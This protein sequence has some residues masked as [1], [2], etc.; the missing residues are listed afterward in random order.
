MKLR[1]N[2]ILFSPF[3]LCLFSLT[4]SLFLPPL[5]PSTSPSP[6]SL[7]SF[8]SCFSPLFPVLGLRYHAL[9]LVQDHERVSE[10][11][12]GERREEGDDIVWMPSTPLMYISFH[13]LT[14]HTH[15]Q[16]PLSHPVPYLFPPPHHTHSHTLQTHKHHPPHPP[17]PPTGHG[18]A[19]DTV[20]NLIWIYGGY[21]TYFPYIN[22]DGEGS[23]MYLRVV[24]CV[25]CF[26]CMFFIYTLFAYFLLCHSVVYRLLFCLNIVVLL[27]HLFLGFFFTS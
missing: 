14:L 24:C 25:L 10:G 11:K 26:V 4:S 15:T 6:P 21:N 1:T 16:T 22:T 8:S 2:H 23:G 18:S 17:L 5:L 3:F 27:A 9:P 19:F 7:L 12:R 20:N 13:S